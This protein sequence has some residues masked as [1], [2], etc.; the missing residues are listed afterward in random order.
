MNKYTKHTY[1]K[2]V[3]EKR[4]NSKYTSV[5]QLCRKSVN[6]VKFSETDD[7]K[8]QCCS[9]AHDHTNPTAYHLATKVMHRRYVP[10]P[11]IFY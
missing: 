6:R 7:A 8:K 2:M 5:I 11:I 1:V 4:G 3:K 9:T 10:L